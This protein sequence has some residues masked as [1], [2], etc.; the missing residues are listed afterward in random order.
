MMSEGVESAQTHI[1]HQYKST[2]LEKSLFVIFLAAL[3]A[4]GTITIILGEQTYVTPH[5]KLD[6]EIFTYILAQQ[7]P[8]QDTY[9][10]L[11]NGIPA[12]GM[13]RPSSG[14]QIFYFIDNHVLSDALST[15]FIMIVAYLFMY[16][17][18][19]KIRTRSWLAIIIS[20]LYAS[21]PFNSTYGLS[22][23]GIPIILYAAMLLRE[24][25]NKK[26]ILGIAL[27]IFYGLFSSLVLV[28]FA[29]LI[30][31][32]IYLFVLIAKRNKRTS[33]LTAGGLLA[34]T[35]V[36]VLTNMN[37][38]NQ[39]LF[40]G[41]KTSHKTEIIL[42]STEVTIK[43]LIS[44]FV[45]GHYHAPSLH[46]I[47][48]ATSFISIMLFAIFHINRQHI[49]GK[50]RLLAHW[51][52]SL[53]AT[54]LVIS[55]FYSLFCSGHIVALRNNMPAGLKAF[56]LARFHWLFPCIWYMAAGSS[57]ELILSLMKKHIRIIVVLLIPIFLVSLYSNAK[58][59]N[60][61]RNA[62]KILFPDTLNLRIS[63]I[64]WEEFFAEDIFDLIE[65]DIAEEKESYRVL[66]IGMHPSVAL[67]NGF[68]CL[69][70][71]SNNYPAEYKHQFYQIIEQELFKSDEL[72]E[73]FYNWGNRCYTFSHEIGRKYL[74]SKNETQKITNLQINTVAIQEMKG[75]YIFSTVEIANHINNSLKFIGAYQT[76]TSHYQIWVYEIIE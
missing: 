7:H 22:S 25:N 31:G 28:G 23:M 62:I 10:E 36:Y 73:Y 59:N 19:V 63:S 34:L 55:I 50:S 29:V 49:S 33:I 37:L 53:V 21:L 43:S 3:L 61:Y 57:I 64:T 20:F 54:A 56:N 72:M 46:M 16:L 44:F 45:R 68:Y 71:Y 75:R 60:I 5:D 67:Y 76:D 58:P 47:F 32:T 12:T 2:K 27:I 26:N 35:V 8:N 70:G 11:M 40:G 24:R 51:T 1:K 14:S 38:I 6:G 9:P 52:V 42:K 4:L 15:I 65:Q 48:V 69:D 18:L 13:H 17:C 30:V 41:G 74:V 39:I 66:S